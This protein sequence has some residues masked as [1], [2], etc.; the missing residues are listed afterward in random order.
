MKSQC[1]HQKDKDPNRGGEIIPL[2]KADFQKIKLWTLVQAVDHYLL[3]GELWKNFR[4]RSGVDDMVSAP[5][6]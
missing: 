2:A 4:F 3:S 1:P 6:R 5:K